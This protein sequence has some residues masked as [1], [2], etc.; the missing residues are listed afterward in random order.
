MS[1]SEFTESLL[2]KLGMS[3]QTFWWAV[4]NVSHCLSKC[5]VEAFY[6][7]WSKLKVQEEVQ[8]GHHV[9]NIEVAPVDHFRPQQMSLPLVRS[10]QPENQK[11]ILFLERPIH[12][13][14]KLQL[15]S[16]TFASFQKIESLGNSSIC[17]SWIIQCWFIISKNFHV[18]SL[19]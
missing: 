3:S 7:L 18:G 8:V 13:N 5:T 9:H 6:T 16:R 10:R 14:C 2:R 4:V 12:W 11:F 17:L 1:Y 19:A 15:S